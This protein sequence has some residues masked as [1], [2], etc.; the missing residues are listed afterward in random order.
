MTS[1]NDGDSPVYRY[2]MIEHAQATVSLRRNEIRIY[3]LLMWRVID[4]T[5]MMEWSE[6]RAVQYSARG[7]SHENTFSVVKGALASN[8][9]HPLI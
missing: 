9:P 6:R 7:K 1:K 8:S 5:G 4:A 3:P 2:A